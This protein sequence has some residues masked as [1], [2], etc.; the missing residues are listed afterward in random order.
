[1]ISS[2][3]IRR[4]YLIKKTHID[5]KNRIKTRKRNILIWG[6][7]PN[8]INDNPVMVPEVTPKI[9]LE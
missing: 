4:M 7:I 8:N 3:E 9:T 2:G 6:S 5:K 1:V